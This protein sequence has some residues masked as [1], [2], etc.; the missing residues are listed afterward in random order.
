MYQF[1]VPLERIRDQLTIKIHPRIALL[2]TPVSPH[3]ITDK[4]AHLLVRSVEGVPANIEYTTV[5]LDRAAK[6]A[7]FSI[8]I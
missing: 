4:Y 1:E 8:S 3:Q 6:P 5:D 7:Y 2:R